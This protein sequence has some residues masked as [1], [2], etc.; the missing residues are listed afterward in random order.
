MMKAVYFKPW[1]SE[2]HW[3][4]R[5]SLLLMLLSSL[6]QLGMFVMVQN[7]VVSYLGAQPED[8]SFAVMCTYAGIITVIPL[9]FR[10]FKF[11]EP[12]S[13]LLVS[14]MLAILLNLL[15]FNCKDINLFLV[16]RFLQGLL[17][18]NV[19]VVT[20]LLIFTRIE[21]GRVKMVAPAVFYGAIF[22]N[23]VLIGAVGGVVVES[24]DWKVTYY[25]LIGA[26]GLT[27]LVILLMLTRRSGHR[28]YPLYQLDWQGSILF[29]LAAL[30]FAYTIIYGSKYYWFSDSRIRYSGIAA[31]IGSMLFLYRQSIVRRP[32]I[33]LS[34]FRSPGFIG[35]VGVLA[36]Y[37][38]SKDSI[39]M[40]YNY[41]GGVLKWSA[42]QVI[43]LGLCNVSAMVVV[44][45][46]AI[47]MML[48][49]KIQIVTLMVIGF[50]LMAGFNA[51]MSFSI[52]PD[53]GMGD[54]MLP[55]ILQGASSG[56]L[57]VPI[58]IEVLARAGANMGVSGLVI[59]AC[60]RFA[61][62]SNSF[63]G[64]YN[65]QLYF[66]QKF[67]DSFLGYLSSD[68]PLTQEWISYYRTGFI[69]KGFSADQASAL[70]TATLGQQLGKQSQL[71]TYRAVFMFFGI[72]LGLISMLL[73][74]VLIIKKMRCYWP[75]SI[76]CY[77]SEV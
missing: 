39:N 25:C 16:I 18:G 74:G 37:Y 59:A 63:A 9:Q 68:N 38:G 62:T 44:L 64:F 30:A 75:Q 6:S 19:L 11:F 60:T 29:A 10:F 42:L 50:A 17:T 45:V 52:T 77:Q 35:A 72:G 4:V 26:Q 54:L 46:F 13:Y 31:L 41:A 70:A 24:F 71:L 23:I 1:I 40:V 7:Y 27:I 5:F 67:K 48:A 65:L 36:V 61:A 14:L 32:V 33:H 56:L 12:R 3:G 49:E 22:S 15:C 66:N 76:K 55:V 47:R 20:L 51:W 21:P 43:T 8:I 34:V 73:L 2:W 53:L 69:S 57:F 58:M 28:P